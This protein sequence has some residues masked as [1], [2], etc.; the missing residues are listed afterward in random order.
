MPPKEL[1]GIIVS[2]VGDADEKVVGVFGDFPRFPVGLVIKGA[3]GAL[4]AR[5]FEEFGIDGGGA[6]GGLVEEA[7]VGVAGAL[8]PAL[9]GERNRA[10]EFGE[11]VEMF[12]E[13]VFDFAADFVDAWVVEGRA[14]RGV[15]AGE[16]LGHGGVEGGEDGTLCFGILVDGDNAVA[17]GGVDDLGEGEVLD[18][19]FVGEEAR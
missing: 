18:L 19:V 8:F 17:G 16:D 12:E 10:G 9:D 11:S 3:Q 14:V 7:K 4:L 5:L 15:E 13:E 2:V 1:P 6:A